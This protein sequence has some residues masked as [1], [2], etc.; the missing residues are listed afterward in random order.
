MFLALVGV[1]DFL[2]AVFLFTVGPG[3]FPVVGEAIVD[4]FGGMQ[5]YGVASLATLL[6]QLLLAYC[7]W[8][9]RGY[10]WAVTLFLMA[11]YMILAVYAQFIFDGVLFVLGLVFF[12][13][14]N[15]LIIY[16]RFKPHV[17][18][19]FGKAPRG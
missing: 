17:K 4:F 13:L 16:Y 12:L 2:S 8:N 1:L 19:F 9:G 6:V 5:S 11:G 18:A 15:S 3:F 7:L 10:A 14:F